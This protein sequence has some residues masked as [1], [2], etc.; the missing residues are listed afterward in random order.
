VVDGTAVRSVTRIWLELRAL[1]PVLLPAAVPAAQLVVAAVVPDARLRVVVAAA[2]PDAQPRVVVT[3]VV[4]DARPRVVV[5]A[6]V[7][8]S[9][10]NHIY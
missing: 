10:A 8:L 4:K 1:E 3:A 6:A 2:V 7:V 5:A 9:A